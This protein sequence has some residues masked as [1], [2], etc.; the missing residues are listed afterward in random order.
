MPGLDVFEGLGTALRMA[1]ETFIGSLTWMDRI[2][3][4]V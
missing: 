1:S 4:I 2:Y 3:R